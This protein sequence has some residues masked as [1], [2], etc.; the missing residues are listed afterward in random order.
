MKQK[1]KGTLRELGLTDG[2]TRVYLALLGKPETTVG[3]VIDK[4]QISSSKVYV[5]LEKLIQ[6][7]L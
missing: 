1:I 4:A 5:I 6:K 7:G 3:P 2:E